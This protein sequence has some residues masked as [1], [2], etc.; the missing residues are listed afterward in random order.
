MFRKLLLI[1]I[2]PISL[3][4]FG[5]TVSN[6]GVYPAS[7]TPM[8][9]SPG[10]GFVGN[11]GYISGVAGNG[12][13]TASD[14]TLTSPPPTAG[15]T[16]AGRAG[17]S[18]FSPM[19]PGIPSPPSTV[20]YTNASPGNTVIYTNAVPV[21]T[22][23]TTRV[24]SEPGDLAS[25]VYISAGVPN[26]NGS[27]LSLGDV[28]AQNKSRKGAQNARSYTNADVQKLISRNGTG[29]FME[30]ANRPPAGVPAPLQNPQTGSAPPTTLTQSTSSATSATSGQSSNQTANTV[31]VPGTQ[32]QPVAGAQN[33]Q[34]TNRENA[35]TTPQIK[36]SPASNAQ[37]DNQ[38][39]ATSTILPLLGLIGLVSSGAGLW[40]RKFRK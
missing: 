13:I 8:T 25:S 17:I 3:A 40:Y 36:Q 35:S 23:A 14:V 15:I 29:N 39:P 38:L 1:A 18:D 6:G 30:A 33:T 19:N 26:T 21:N 31:N 2:L 24:S 37:E 9:G 32:A 11:N 34:T 4:V 28:A 5:Q 7:T 27:S 12:Q 22:G 10:S 20:A 16:D